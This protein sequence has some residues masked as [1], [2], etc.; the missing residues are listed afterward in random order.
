MPR[1]V[2]PSFWLFSLAASSSLWYG[3]HQVGAVGDEDP[4]G[5]VDAP[6]GELV[7]LA[8]EGLRLE[9]D[10]VADDAGDPR[11]QDAR[12]I[13]RRMNCESPMTTVWPAL[14]PPW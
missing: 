10:A 7:E 3:Q 6:L 14:A 9:H 12:G 4:A 1:P 8:E 5:G 2:V 11:M 13:W